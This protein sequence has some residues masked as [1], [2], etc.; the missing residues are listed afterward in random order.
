[1]ESIYC[2]NHP[3][4]RWAVK[5]HDV[6]TGTHVV[7]AL[8]FDCACEAGDVTA[9]S[10]R[11]MARSMDMVMEAIDPVKLATEAVQ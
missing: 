1:M 10:M 3:N 8:C 7:T 6:T 5:I 11:A 9:L 4:R 2:Q